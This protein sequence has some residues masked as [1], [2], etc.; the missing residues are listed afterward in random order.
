MQVEPEIKVD[1]V[2]RH[3]RSRF[4]IHDQKII[5]RLVDV[6]PIDPTVELERRLVERV[7]QFQ[8]AVAPERR[9]QLAR[10]ESAH[11]IQFRQ[12]PQTLRRQPPDPLELILIR[13]SALHQLIAKARRHFIKQLVDYR[14]HF[15]IAHVAPTPMLKLH[16]LAELFEDRM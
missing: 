16:A 1:R 15:I 12:P 5:A 4:I 10:V 9:F 14:A 7:L 13:P 11:A 6:D 2:E 8:F 3:I